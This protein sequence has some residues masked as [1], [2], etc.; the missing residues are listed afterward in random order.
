MFPHDDYM[1]RISKSELFV[2]E[3]FSIVIAVSLILQNMRIIMSICDLI[4]F[5][6][7]FNRVYQTIVN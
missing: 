3:N 2:Q 5:C 1:P 6:L 4:G 7:N